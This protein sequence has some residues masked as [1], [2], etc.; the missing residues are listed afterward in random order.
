M[1]L[2]NNDFSGPIPNALGDLGSLK[3]VNL[4]NNNLI[5][6]SS[7]SELMFLTSL[8]KC[9]NLF[10]IVI[11]E[12]PLN[13]ILP[14]SIGNFSASLQIFGSYGC[15]IRGSIPNQIGDLTGVSL[16]S[17]SDNNLTGIIASTIDGL[18]NLQQLYLDNNEISGSVPNNICSLQKLGAIRLRGNQISG[19]VPSCIGN[20]SSLRHLI[21]A[22][23]FQQFQFKFASKLMKAERSSE[24]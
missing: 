5:I 14:A 22:S 21:L 8:T 10:K 7:F 6:E 1:D 3:L 4:G 18:Q 23:K 2:S 13:D 16:L 9:R 11:G 19:A 15:T 17:L 24:V 20:I 12:S